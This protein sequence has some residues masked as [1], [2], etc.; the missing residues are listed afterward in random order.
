[1]EIMDL[2][3]QYRMVA[4]SCLTPMSPNNLGSQT[5]WEPADVALIYLA[6]ALDNEVTSC[7]LEYHAIA[8]DPKLK[9][10]PVV[11]LRSCS[12]PP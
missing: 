12:D 1:M 2:L 9:A 11:L 6:L 4:Q 10:H 5:P 3:S 7:F 8:L